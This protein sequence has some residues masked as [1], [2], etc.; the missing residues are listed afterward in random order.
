MTNSDGVSKFVEYLDTLEENIVLFKGVVTASEI[1]GDVAI[2][3]EQI[4]VSNVYLE[5]IQKEW[6]KQFVKLLEIGVEWL[7]SQDGVDA[8]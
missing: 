2:S 8:E 5:E 4:E 7:K 6:S 3:E 1:M